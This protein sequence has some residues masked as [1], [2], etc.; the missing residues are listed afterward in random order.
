[1]SRRMEEGLG[2][3]YS[4]REIDDV[5]VVDLK[6]RISL[7][8][9]LGLGQGSGAVLHEMVRGRSATK[10]DFAPHVIVSRQVMIIG[11]YNDFLT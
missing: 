7:A 1:M 2:L 6:G 8:D 4:V 9:S 10:N 3:D 11:L 5:T